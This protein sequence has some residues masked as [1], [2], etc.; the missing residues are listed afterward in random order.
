MMLRNVLIATAVLGA[1]GYALHQFGM[2]QGRAESGPAASVATTPV[3]DPTSSVAAGEAATRR[4]IEQGLKAG[5]VDPATG[6]PILYYHDPMVPGKRFD[7]PA[8]SPFM[9][10]MLVP[11]YGGAGGDDQGTVTVSPRIQQNLG[12]RTAVVEEGALQAMVSAVGSIAWNERDQSLV[13]ARATGYLEKLHVRA[14]LDRVRAGQ[15][16]AELYVP[17]WVAAQEEYLAVRRIAP[18][19][20]ALLAAARQRLLLAGM[21]ETQVA[22][23]CTT[24]WSR[25]F[26][27]MLPTT[28]TMG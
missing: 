27:A 6:K 12:V 20:A 17:D 28:L 26:Q 5:E 8:K 13:Q 1:G 15:P 9:D 14:T 25:S 21:S 4:H 18:G 11:V 7:A 3:E 16:F 22:R 19:D 10:M 23:A 24:D 2:M